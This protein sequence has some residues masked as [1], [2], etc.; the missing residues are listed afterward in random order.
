MPD[1]HA[2]QA[3]GAL[4]AAISRAVVR[5]MHDYTGRDQAT[6]RTT[7]RDDVVTVTVPDAML[8]GERHLVAGGRTDVVADMRRYVQQTMRVDLSH[9]VEELTERRVV[10]FNGHSRLAPAY[11]LAI[12]TLAAERPRRPG[13]APP[14]GAGP[15]VRHQFVRRRPRSCARPPRVRRGGPS[16]SA[17]RRSAACARHAR[18]PTA[19]RYSFSNRAPSGVP[20]SHSSQKWSSASSNSASRPVLPAFARTAMVGPYLALKCSP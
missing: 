19:R 17:D 20:R 2:D 11:S 18:V 8:E 10:A 5:I 7:I 15:G 16:G 9:A 4:C 14:P 13:E 6:A 1:I 3:G 12:F